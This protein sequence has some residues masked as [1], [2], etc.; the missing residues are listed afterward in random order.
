MVKI[1]FKDR[2]PYLLH[3]F[4]NSEDLDGIYIGAIGKFS[5]IC[6]VGHNTSTELKTIVKLK[7]I[8]C[9]YCSGRFVYPVSEQEKSNSLNDKKV[10][11]L[12]N[13]LWALK[14]DKAKLLFNS[15]DGFNVTF[16]SSKILVWKCSLGHC[17]RAKVNSVVS[18]DSGC[19]FCTYKKLWPVT[20]DQKYISLQ[21][22]IEKI[23]PLRNDLL[24]RKPEIVHQLV[25]KDDGFKLIGP[26][27]KLLCRNNL[28]EVFAFPY[29]S[30]RC[31]VCDGKK[32]FELTP[33]EKARIIEGR[34]NSLKIH[35][36]N[37]LLS[38]DFEVFDW[39]IDPYDGLKVTK[40]AQVKLDI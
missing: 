21:M 1:L 33:N 35:E 8:P 4:R 20:D 10:S 22:R 29:R 37:D 7:R 30:L 26:K 12:R 27:L 31:G 39:L 28:H 19:S 5:T 2:Y 14:P 16:N 13:D 40:A 18:M 34:D 3:L 15:K 32:L 25:N 6:S 24:A 36:R 17:W 9:G 23:D 11:S 38:I